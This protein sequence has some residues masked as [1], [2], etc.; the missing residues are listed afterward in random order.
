MIKLQKNKNYYFSKVI[1]YI[2]SNIPRKIENTY[3]DKILVGFLSKYVKIL[4][5]IKKLD[6]LGYFEE[7]DILIRSLYEIMVEVAYLE[8]NPEENYERLELYSYYEDKKLM[9]QLSKEFN[10]NV[11]NI[12]NVDK[13]N[14]M[15]DI[16]ESKD[17]KGSKSYCNG[18]NIKDTAKVVDD[19]WKG[20]YKAV[21]LVQ[22]YFN[23]Y[24]IDCLFC[25][26]SVKILENCS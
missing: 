24:K 8:L 7:C 15:A 2:E 10:I 13:I 5:S 11:D 16:Y 25:H 21:S 18:L 14:H 1:N 12:F 19:C 20:K 23:I 17:Y 3:R 22:L 6:K 4:K 9:E 26:N